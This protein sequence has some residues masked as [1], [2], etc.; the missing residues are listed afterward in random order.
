MPG[1]TS[2]TRD[3]AFMAQA[4]RLASK[5][6]GFTSPNPMVGAVVVAKGR[7][8]G[9]GYHPRVGG[10][11]AEVVALRQAGRRSRGATLYLSLEPCSHTDKRTPPCVPLIL[12]S[13][14]RRIVVAMRDPNPKVSGRG[15]RALKKAGL[16]V[17]L[18]SLG[19]EAEQLN[20]A[21]CQWQRI[22]RPLVTLKA[23]MT[24]DGKIAT[25]GGESQW[26]TG[27]EARRHAHRLR[28]QMDA[29]MVGIGTVRED[30]P[31]LTARL[32]RTVR[33]PLRVVVDSRASIPLR[34]KVLSPALR[35]GTLVA[36]TDRAP[37][38]R[39]ARL[40]RLGVNV[41]KL[42]AANGRVP[43]GPLL[44]TLGRL[45]VTTVLIEG[46]SELNAAA[47][48]AGFVD[49]VVL[50]VAPR[51]LGGQDAKAVIGGRSPIRIGQALPLIDVTVRRLGSDLLIEGTVGRR[52]ARL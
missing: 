48:R 17:Q 20:A 50:Y 26:I 15:L 27:S 7:I 46:G 28:S 3:T 45:A 2:R 18:G 21:Y 29:V 37:A 12:R 32:A 42:K 41:L 39:I 36:V 5:G 11:H 43:L 25:A 35:A 44:K 8:V 51:L 31:R 49:R 40:R 33:Q 14:V 24:M 52:P 16:D 38:H 9:R 47:V 10:P 34:A 22:G 4:L 23:G 19:E 1:K 6:R 13:G 30:D